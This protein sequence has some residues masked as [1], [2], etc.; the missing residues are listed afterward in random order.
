M[1]SK[2]GVAS[3]GEGVGHTKRKGLEIL[4]TASTKGRG[5]AKLIFSAAFIGAIGFAIGRR[6]SK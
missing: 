5:T 6:S 3:S 1:N 2:M 4:V